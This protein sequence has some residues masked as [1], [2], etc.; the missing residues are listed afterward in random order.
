MLITMFFMGV[1]ILRNRLNPYNS[2]Y[3]NKLQVFRSIGDMLIG[4]KIP[5][6]ADIIKFVITGGDPR[7]A[8][9]GAVCQA[10]ID[11]ASSDAVQDILLSLDS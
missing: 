10:K 4:S 9:C 3:V 8:G 7:V 5:P 1:S 11:K 6:Q 2:L